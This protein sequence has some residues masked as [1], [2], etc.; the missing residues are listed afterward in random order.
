MENRV[1]DKPN[2][3][4]SACL[5]LQPIRYNGEYVKDEI[6]LRLRE[7]CNIIPTCPELEIGLGI[8]RDKIIVFKTET[9]YGLSQPSTNRELTKEMNDFSQIFLRS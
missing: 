1:F 4:L 2:L 8:P 6:T 3:V 5:D 7:H 9:G